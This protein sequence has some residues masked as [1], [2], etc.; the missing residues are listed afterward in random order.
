MKDAFI[1]RASPLGHVSRLLHVAAS[2]ADL[3]PLAKLQFARGREK[4]VQLLNEEKGEQ[5]ELFPRTDFT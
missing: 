3:Y 1:A 4:N 5:K 2:P